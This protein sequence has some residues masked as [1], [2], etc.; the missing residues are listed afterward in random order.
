MQN[1][2]LY[3]WQM[4]FANGSIP[5]LDILIIPEEDGRLNTTVYRRPTHTDLYLQ[6]D[7]HDNIPSKYSVIGTLYHR[8]K[9]TCSSPQHLQKEEQ[10]LTTSLKRCKY[11]TWALN[12]IKLKNQKVTSNKNNKRGTKP[13]RPEQPNIN[14]PHI[15]VPYHRGL[16]ENFKRTCSRQGVQV[17]LKGGL[18]IKNLLMAPKDKDTIMKKIGVIY[19]YKCNRVE[20]DEEYIGESARNFAE[21]FKKHLK[22]PSHIHDHS[23]ISGHSVTIDNFSIVGRENQNL[24]RTIKEALYIRVNNPSLNKN[25]GKYHQPHIWDEVLH[26]ISELKLE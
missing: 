6:W 16:S 21:R 24:L 4:V 23:V 2:I 22:T 15:V 10:H 20:C 5:F 13:T 25:I 18:T 12:R 9:T 19:R 1:L 26:N 17:H 11:P 3:M 14:Q 7:S 8:A